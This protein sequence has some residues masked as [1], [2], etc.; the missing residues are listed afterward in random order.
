MTPTIKNEDI[1]RLKSEIEALRV[2]LLMA[3][4]R[5][6]IAEERMRKFN[7]SGESNK[8]RASR[9]DWL[10]GYI[11]RFV[12]KKYV[13]GMTLRQMHEI[14]VRQFYDDGYIELRQIAR[15]AK[16]RNK[17]FNP[18]NRRGVN[19]IDISPSHS[20]KN[21]GKGEYILTVKVWTSNGW[22]EKKIDSCVIYGRLSRA[23]SLF[24]NKNKN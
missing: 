19:I 11:R 2:Q 6:R 22:V 17:I 4:E 24:V 3:E 15:K 7:R 12:K 18:L 9:I 23:R 13:N 14:L 8:V 21:A 20:P 5:A 1:E 10:T 16:T